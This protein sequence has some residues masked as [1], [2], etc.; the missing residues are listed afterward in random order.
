MNTQF[1]EKKLL[2]L[3]GSELV[4]LFKKYNVFVAGGAITSIFTNSEINDIDVYTRNEDDLL[5]LI[6]EL[7]DHC[8]NKVL[9]ST[10]KSTLFADGELLVQA[11]HFKCFDTAEDIFDSFDFTSVMGAYD[12]KDN[13][14]Y[15][16]D[17]F[18]KHNSQKIIKFNSNTAYP[19]ISALRVQKYEDK[20]YK[21]SKAEYLRIVMTCMKLEINSYEELQEHLGGMYGVNL[22]KLFEDIKDDEFSLQ[23]AIEKLAEITLSDEYFEKPELEF[24]LE[25]DEVISKISPKAIKYVEFKGKIYRVHNSGEIDEESVKYDNHTMLDIKD[26]FKDNKLYKFVKKNEDG[27]YSSYYDDKF[28]Y[29][30]GEIAEA[31]GAVG[32]YSCDKGKLHFNTKEKIK[33]STYF[34][35]KDKVLLEVMFNTDDLLDIDHSTKVTARKVYVVREVPEL[36][37]KMWIGNK[38][39]SKEGAYCDSPLF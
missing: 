35:K 16:H 19:L 14:Y 15:F 3:L 8:G 13:K 34:D 28:T 17:D 33:K 18:M 27:T 30:I 39:V 23:A 7:F 5:G 36:E 11:I 10:K 26:I 25:L 4:D 22:D 37:W 29:K 31:N 24:I 32:T 21:I 20:G 9:S 12:F 38:H 2:K 6:E 1:E